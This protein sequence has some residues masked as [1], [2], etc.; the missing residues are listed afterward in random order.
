M[1]SPD[2]G[3][4]RSTTVN[5][6]I[7][8]TVLHGIMLFAG[9]IVFL[10]ARNR[11]GFFSS[12]SPRT[13]ITFLSIF[14]VMPT[15]LFLGITGAWICA[16]FDTL[17]GAVMFL[18]VPGMLVFFVIL[19]WCAAASAGIEM[20]GGTLDLDGLWGNGTLQQRR[21]VDKQQDQ[22]DASTYALP[23]FPSPYEDD[24]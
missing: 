9:G 20:S 15:V 21:M 3:S 11:S 18:V 19:A 17:V 2:T 7:A 8:A 24:A 22:K 10:R 1:D 13:A 16:V 23:Y 5:I 14:S 12:C 6:A 4:T